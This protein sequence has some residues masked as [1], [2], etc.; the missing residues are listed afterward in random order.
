MGTNKN[1]YVTTPIYYASGMVHI[2]NSY[3]TVVADVFAR[4]HRLKG[5]DTFFLTGMD[6]HGLKIEEAAAKRGLSPQEFVDDIAAKTSNLWSNLKLTNDDFIRTSEPRHV[7][8]VQDVFEQL[9]K[10]GDIY[11]GSYEGW[12]CTPCESFWTDTQVGENHICP[13]CGRPVHKAKEECYFLNLKKYQQQLLDYIKEHPDFIQPETRKNEVVSFVESGLEDLCVSRTTIKCGIPVLS[14]PNHTVY[15]WIDALTNYISALGY[16]SD[17]D[18]N[19][20]KYWCDAKEVIH[21]VGKDILRFHAVYWPIMLM[22]LKLP[23]PFKVYAHGWILM[24]EGKMSKSKGNLV[25]PMDVVNRYGLDALRYYL[26]KEMPLGNDGLF[27]WERF[28]ERFNV[29]LANDLG[30]LVSRTI[31]MINKYFGGKIV[32]ASKKYFAFDDEVEALAAEVVDN[33]K[34][35]FEAFHFQDGLEEVWK[36]ISRANKYIDETMP[37]AL[38]KDETKQEELKDVMYH[39]YEVLRLVSIMIKPV[40]EDTAKI[41]IEELGLKEDEASFDKLVFGLNIENSVIDKPVVLFKRLNL[42]EE[43]EKISEAN[44]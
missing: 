3:S 24:K 22:A 44:N 17:N 11:L 41:I 14:N 27:T 15:V 31:S 6:E 12:Y 40:M 4:Y 42:Q 25:Y 36:L 28:I 32:K 35:D 34:K 9:L 30:N 43:L 37:W 19:Y 2:G 16:K 21:V 26:V 13:D 10:S 7:K 5:D 1:Y 20:Q 23:I 33:Y 38:A 8:V 29:D 39:L 18:A